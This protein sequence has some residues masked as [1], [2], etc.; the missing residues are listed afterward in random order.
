MLTQMRYPIMGP[1]DNPSQ[2]I[3]YIHYT[4]FV[5]NYKLTKNER[6]IKTGSAINSRHSLFLSENES[7]INV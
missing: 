2:V 5:K 3:F 1:S 6:T 7:D 4:R